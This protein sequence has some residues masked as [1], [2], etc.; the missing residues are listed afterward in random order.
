MD[1]TFSTTRLWKT[2]CT[3]RKTDYV[4]NATLFERHVQ[5]IITFRHHYSTSF[6]CLYKSYSFI[7]H[8][9]KC[10]ISLTFWRLNY[11]GISVN[12]VTDILMPKALSSLQLIC[13]VWYQ[14]VHFRRPCGHR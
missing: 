2:L 9:N 3:C 10:R 8:L 11:K 7:M 12:K 6:T 4:E 13:V 5:L 1:R 14:M